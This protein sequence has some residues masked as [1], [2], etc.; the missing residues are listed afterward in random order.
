[1]T[2][3][4]TGFSPD[5][6]KIINTCVETWSKKSEQISY[7]SI[8]KCASSGPT[9]KFGVGMG[10]GIG[11][12]MKLESAE[13]SAEPSASPSMPSTPSCITSNSI[14][15][16]SSS[17]PT[18]EPVFIQAESFFKFPEVTTDDFV[19][20]VTKE[21]LDIFNSMQHECNKLLM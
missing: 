14:P 16:M 17:S 11:M 4:I 13:P 2:S 1:M 19:F 12:G 6:F 8:S 20:P 15:G 10:I 21:D 18:P 9:Y 7:T 5:G 3:I